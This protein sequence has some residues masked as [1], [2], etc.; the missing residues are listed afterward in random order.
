LSE[1]LAKAASKKEP[2]P[3]ILDLA[4]RLLL[5]AVRVQDFRAISHLYVELGTLTVL[6]GE[7]NVGKTSFLQALDTAIGSRRALE[8]D[9]FV[10]A[11]G[12]RTTAF[13]IDARISPRTGEDFDEVTSERIGAAIQFPAKGPAYFAIRTVGRPN[14][15]GSGLQLDRRFL[16]GWAESRA[17][18]EGLASLDRV[19]LREAEL[20][21]VFLLDARRDLVD[22][23]RTRGSHWGRLVADLGIASPAS[24]EVERV[25]RE[26]GQRIVKESPLLQ[27]MSKELEGLRNALGSA[28][29]G[30]AISPLPE[31]LAELSRAMDVLVAAPGS[32]ELPMR[33]QGMGARNLAAVM[34]FRSFMQM[35]MGLAQDVR[36]LGIAAFEEPEAHLHPQAHAAMF[37][38]ISDL[39]GQKII[40]THSPHVSRTARIYDIRVFRR[41]ANAIE[42]RRIPPFTD[43][44]PTFSEAD[45]SK[46][47]R[48]VQRNNGEVL[49][50][51]VAVIFEGET[52][53]GALPVFARHFWKMEGAAHGVSLVRA[54]GAQNFQH[55]VKVLDALGI[56][57]LIFAD[58]DGEGREGVDRAGKALKRQLDGASDEVVMLPKDVDFEQ[59]LVDEGFAT[60][61]IRAIHQVFGENTLDQYRSAN[62]GNP[63]SAD[64]DKRDYQSAG[65]E[66]RLCRDFSRKFMKGSAG[67][68]VAAAIVSGAGEKGPAGWPRA[69][70]ELLHRVSKKLGLKE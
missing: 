16:N 17:E 34:V 33:L 63:Y 9:L 59:Y 26:T 58:G 20:V 31:R 11:D 28:V 70:S 42:C 5:D 23:L 7:N 13:V 49:F 19:G 64:G 30:V 35:R 37:H 36:P 1:R 67:A 3:A 24:D 51:R 43:G 66:G 45:L 62:H 69:V 65:W 14:P 25:L 52:E 56:P 27:S 41:A 50:A 60:E 44:T 48:F 47:H 22:E 57:W 12:T 15:D 53:E 40:S 39:P 61:V 6:V 32:A 55:F 18:A 46:V 29:S 68:A 10:A 38:L 54:D 8:E 21:N 4:D 2:S